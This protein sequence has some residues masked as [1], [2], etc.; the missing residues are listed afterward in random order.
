MNPVPLFH[1]VKQCDHFKLT[2]ALW[3]SFCFSIVTLA[4]IHPE[5][6]SV[7]PIYWEAST[8][9]MQ[10]EKLYQLYT[11]MKVGRLFLYLPQSAILQV[12]FAVLPTQLAEPLWRIANITL[13]A[14]SVFLVS[15]LIPSRKS[16]LVLTSFGIPLA[17]S[18]AFNGQINLTL[19]SL[20]GILSYTLIHKK[21]KTSV[22]ICLIGFAFKPLMIV[23][24]LLIC[25]VFYKQSL[26]NAIIGMILLFLFPFFTQSSDYVFSQYQQFFS[27]LL[28]IGQSPDYRN[29]ATFFGMLNYFGI[30]TSLLF[31]LSISTILALATFL[32]C[33][34]YQQTRTHQESCLIL[35]SMAA[36]YILLF[37]PISENNTYVIAAIA[38]GYFFVINLE[39]GKNALRR[40]NSAV[41]I[42]CLLLMAGSHQWASFLTPGNVRWPA[43]LALTIFT[44]YIFAVIQPAK[45]SKVMNR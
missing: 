23:P 36:F 11:G 7:I 17:I 8:N 3:F 21:F 34:R 27:L 1:V 18:S 15:S 41:M 12:P 26:V 10:G 5:I 31:E 39:S 38:M 13:Y 35:T 16:F 37:N 44:I 24:L 28:S 43:P 42:F 29:Y 25:G 6:Q 40:W 45:I 22:M 30:S 2:I 4:A 33:L 14:F 20:L 32:Y 19:A 9:W